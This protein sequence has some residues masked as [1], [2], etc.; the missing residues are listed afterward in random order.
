MNTEQILARAREYIEFESSADFRGE[1]QSLLDRKDFDELNERFYT[2]LSFGTG[3]LRGI[4]GGGFNRMNPYI[5]RRATQGVAEYVLEAGSGKSPSAVVAFDSRRFSPEFALET[6]LVFCGNGVK[7]YLFSSLRPTPELSFAVRELGAAVGVV[8]TASHNPAQYNG[9]KVYWSD[10]GQIVPPHDT[11]IVKRVLAVEAIR[12]IDKADALGRGMLSIIDDQIDASYIETVKSQAIRPELIRERGKELKV[13]YTPL[14]GAGAMP[15]SHA[16]SSMGIEVIFVS[17]QAS[18]DGNFATV[19][20]PNPEESSAMQLA[21]DLGRKEK[22]DLVMGTDPDAD[23]LGI[24][25][26]SGDD[27]VLLSG[28]QLGVLLT[29]YVFS[30]RAEQQ[31][32]P[33]KPALVKTIVTTELQRRIAES[34]GA[35]VFD[36]LTGFKYIAEKIR[37]FESGDEGIEYVFGGE[38]SYGYLVG[39]A[40]RD[41]D[42]VS[43]AAMSAEMTLYHRANGRTLLEHLDRIYE[44]YGYFEEKLFTKYFEGQAGVRTMAEL[45]EKLRGDP[46]ARIGEEDVVT[47]KDY[48]TGQ[49][50]EAASKKPIGP[51]NLPTS[52]VLQ[53]ILSKGSVVTARPSGTEPKVKFYASCCSEPESPLAEAKTRISARIAAITREIQTIIGE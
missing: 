17:E 1:V 46:P 39:T 29:D 10:G 40:V 50:I 37:E 53:F 27:F 13:V 34:Y 32:L 45:M 12:T 14:H 19:K 26:P 2:D 51:T 31:S 33:G 48:Q 5:V 23:R 24:A 42:A 43:A 25:A 38:E 3:G 20:Y 44:R 28:N 36:T 41:K 16:L 18:P 15:L 8:I 22:A 4:I 47:I 35:C 7:T 11:G 49:I 6:A 30:S 52:N 21:L 9:Y